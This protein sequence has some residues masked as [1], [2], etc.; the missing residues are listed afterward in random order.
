M[1][2]NKPFIITEDE[3]TATFLQN[4]GLILLSH[5]NN[6]YIFKNDLE[7]IKDFSKGKIS[8]TDKLFI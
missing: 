3:K 7:K 4:K 1:M 5:N 8:F 6:Q 2:A